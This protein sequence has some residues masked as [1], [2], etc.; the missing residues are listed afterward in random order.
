MKK[1]DLSVS[2]STTINVG[3]YSSIK[4]TVSLTIKDIDASEIDSKYEKI[5]E[6]LD[7]LM[8]METKIL[9]CEADSVGTVGFRKYLE[10]IKNVDE[11]E[12]MLKEIVGEL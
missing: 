9:A 7:Y 4:P 11:P 2:R 6:A 3:N 12:K 8:L 1:C 10:I 5:S